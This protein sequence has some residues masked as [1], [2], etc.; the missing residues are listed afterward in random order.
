MSSMDD[1]PPIVTGVAFIAPMPRCPTHGQM[2]FRCDGWVCVG[3]DGEGCDYELRGFDQL[4][5]FASLGDI[6]ISGQYPWEQG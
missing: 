4:G 3:W 6:G 1:Q 2:Q 5:L